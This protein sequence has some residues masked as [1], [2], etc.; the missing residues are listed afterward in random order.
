MIDSRDGFR[1]IKTNSDTGCRNYAHSGKRKMCLFRKQCIFRSCFGVFVTYFHGNEHIIK[2]RH[3]VVDFFLFKFLRNTVIIVRV[4]RVT[5]LTE[6][7][8]LVAI[9]VTLKTR[10]ACLQALSE[11]VSQ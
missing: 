1:H 5:V 6:I 4:Y 7:A 8:S 11:L 9:S 3:M 10:C 2:I